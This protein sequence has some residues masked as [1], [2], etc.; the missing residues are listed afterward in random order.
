[1]KCPSCG[2]ETTGKFCEFC[3]SEMPK[4]KSGNTTINITNNYYTEEKPRQS[5]NRQ[6]QRRQKPKKKRKTWLW[7]LGWICIFPLP[8]T[9]L[10]LRKKDMKPALKYG[11][12]AVAWIIYLLIGLGGNSSDSKK[13]ETVSSPVNDNAIEVVTND[14]ATD[15]NTDI[16]V[17]ETTASP[18]E[19]SNNDEESV[20]SFISSMVDNYNAIASAKIEFVEDF[21]PSENSNGHYRTE[22]RLNAYKDA[23]GKSYVYGD[24]TV[25]IIAYDTLFGD[26]NS[27]IY[28]DDA[29]YELVSELVKYMPK[30]MDSELTDSDLQE[31]IDIVTEKKP[32]ANGVY[33]GKH[34]GMIFTGADDLGY[35]LMLKKE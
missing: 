7:V 33:F 13:S 15:D 17:E 22:F 2:A 11:I 27:R 21:T 26:R 20:D 4:E 28:T 9:I 8:L 6:P 29:P 5:A 14:T 34:T 3:G 25:D 12:I 31:A 35:D 19:D 10:L 24:T 23:V 18:E 30:Y 16:V 1:M 32:N